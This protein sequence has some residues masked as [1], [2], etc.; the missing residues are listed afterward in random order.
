MEN[1]PRK[2]SVC[3]YLFVALSIMVSIAIMLFACLTVGFKSYFMPFG[4]WSL[5]FYIATVLAA[6]I[7]PFAYHKIS[8]SASIICAVLTFLCVIITITWLAYFASFSKNVVICKLTDANNFS[9]TTEKLKH[10][11]GKSFT[12]VLIFSTPV[13]WK[14]AAQTTP[15]YNSN[16]SALIVNKRTEITKIL[17]AHGIK[18]NFTD[19]FEMDSGKKSDMCYKELKHWRVCKEITNIL[20]GLFIHVPI[21]DISSFSSFPEIN[22]KKCSF[23]FMEVLSLKFSYTFGKKKGGFTSS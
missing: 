9:V 8:R 18:G 7:L 16:L 22:S 5:I 17:N 11:L 4:W 6:L 10:F 15:F 20:P 3:V 19:G 12:S 2:L 21:K 23:S 13:I 14:T 1:Q